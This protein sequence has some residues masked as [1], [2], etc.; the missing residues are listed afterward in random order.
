MVTATTSTVVST[1]PPI[2]A[3][4]A[5]PLPATAT[6]TPVQAKVKPNLYTVDVVNVSSDS[7]TDGYQ[8]MDNDV[9]DRYK[10]LTKKRPRYYVSSDSDTEQVQKSSGS[11][12]NKKSSQK[13]GPVKKGSKSLQ[14]KRRKRSPSTSDE[15]PSFDTIQTVAQIEPHHESTQRDDPSQSADNSDTANTSTPGENADETNS[16]R[17]GTEL[18][19]ITSDHNKSTHREKIDIQSKVLDITFSNDSNIN[20]QSKV[21]GAKINKKSKPTDTNKQS[22]VSDTKTTKQPK[23]STKTASNN[24]KT[25]N[26][27]KLP[28][29]QS[30]KS[31]KTN[32]TDLSNPVVLLQDCRQNQSTSTITRPTETP[33]HTITSSQFHPPLQLQYTSCDPSSAFNQPMAFSQPSIDAIRHVVD[34]AMTSMNSSINFTPHQK[35]IQIDSRHQ[36]GLVLLIWHQIFFHKHQKDTTDQ[37]RTEM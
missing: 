15:G 26:K 28:G 2:V 35:L 34:E 18:P 12:S 4:A 6:N 30:N 22:K 7:Q 20:K 31:K 19:S 8:N 33:P 29:K 25:N 11:K 37:Y 32:K 16:K 10:R 9:S 3:T 1:T 21:S 13:N 24:N 14:D 27:S 5:S 17:I 23:V 36:V